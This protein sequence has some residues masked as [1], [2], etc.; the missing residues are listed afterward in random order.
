VQEAACGIEIPVLLVRGAFSELVKESHVQE[1]LQLVPHA[2]YVNVGDARHMV[3]GDRN[4]QFS[5]VVTG[6][7]RGVNY[8]TFTQ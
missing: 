3:A 1:F 7:V 6:V 4:D 5:T 8:I 2:E